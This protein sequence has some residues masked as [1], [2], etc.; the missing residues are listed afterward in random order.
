M[1]CEVVASAWV[2]SIKCAAILRDFTV[3]SPGNSVDSL[4]PLSVLKNC[5]GVGLSLFLVYRS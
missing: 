4:I 1:L 5:R 3:E 2:E